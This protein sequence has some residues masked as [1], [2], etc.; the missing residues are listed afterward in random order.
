VWPNEP[1]SYA[2]NS[3]DTDRTSNARQAKGNASDKMEYPGP[4]GWGLGREANHLTSHMVREAIKNWTE[5]QHTR[6]WIELPGL[7]HSKLVRVLCRKLR[8][9]YHLWTKRRLL[10]RGKKIM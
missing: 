8:K 10:L 5:K 7:R 3:V 1:E 6:A 2:G 4:P 9:S